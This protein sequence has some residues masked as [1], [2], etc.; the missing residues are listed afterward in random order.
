[1][2][3]DHTRRFKSVVVFISIFSGPNTGVVTDKKTTSASSLKARE[4]LS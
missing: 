1:M 4:G 2:L 3:I